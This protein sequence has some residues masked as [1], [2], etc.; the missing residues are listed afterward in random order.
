MRR[1]GCGQATPSPAFSSPQEEVC[2]VCRDTRTT[3]DELSGMPLAMAYVPWQEW[4]NIY[5]AEKGFCR[6]TIFEE[7]DKPFCG[8]GGCQ[9]VR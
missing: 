8:I 3:Y 4:Q 9:N 1:R 6:G 5:E 7:L 2:P